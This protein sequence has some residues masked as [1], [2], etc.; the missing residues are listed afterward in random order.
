MTD[1]NEEVVIDQPSAKI[2]DDENRENKNP[3][4]TSQK[5]QM[6]RKQVRTFIKPLQLPL[7]EK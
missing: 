3:V 4:I 5:H 1:T 2:L 7:R 6:K